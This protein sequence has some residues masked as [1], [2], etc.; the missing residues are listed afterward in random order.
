[1]SLHII[2]DG[3]NFILQSDQFN[4]RDIQAAREAVVDALAAYKRQR[5]HKITIVF[6]G[7][8]APVVLQN[9]ER[10]KGINITFSRHAE[11]ADTVI[12]R[13]AAREKHKAL[14]VSSDRE[15]VDFASH[16]GAATISSPMFEQKIAMAQFSDTAGDAADENRGWVPTTKK[17]GP[18]RR[19]SK[20][21]RR[22]RN[23]IRKL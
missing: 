18:R 21:Q 7:S 15:V 16:H 9:R 5:G 2:I 11:L 1:M 14:V 19:L 6:D 22:N 17:K 3:Y 10:R 13:M 23:K 12:K 8:N 20:R 4:K